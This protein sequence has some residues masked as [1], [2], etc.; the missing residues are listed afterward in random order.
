[1]M[2]ASA[3]MN[4]MIPLICHFMFAR[5]ITNSTEFILTVYDILIEQ[6]DKKY[7]VDIYNKLYE[8]AISNV[9]RTAKRNQTIWNMQDIRGINTSI[10][11]LQSVQNVL[12]NI[13]PKYRYDGNL[14][15]LNYKSILR[16]TGFQILDIEYEYSFVSLSSSRRDEDLNSEFDKFE[17]FLQKQDESLLV[18]NQVAS[19]DAMNQIKL[20]YGPFDPDEI[21]YYKHRLSSGSKCTVNS[22]QRDLIFNL[23]FKYFGDTNTINAINLD[24]YIVLIIAAKR[25]LEAS[26]MV[27]LPHIVS[28]KVIRLATRKNVNKKELTK[29]ESSPLW[30]KIKDKYRNDKIEKHI[31][32]IIAVILSSEFEI[33]DPEDSELDGQRI[34]VIPELICE[35]ILMYISLI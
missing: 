25:I 11:T 8:T 3:I 35:E 7:D 33:I 31:L 29:L 19:D 24:D 20:M 17:S 5:G 21:Q 4:C 9:L 27:M 15:H 10:H 22:F 16:N 1:M 28:S 18:Q 26:G 13:M 2:K 34:T 23:F 32:G 6:Y 30:A 14:V 12:I